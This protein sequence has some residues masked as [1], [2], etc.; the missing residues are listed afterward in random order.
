MSK[1]I[2]EDGNFA[3]NVIHYNGKTVIN[4]TDSQYLD[5]GYREY[6]EPVHEEETVTTVTNADIAKQREAAYREESD[7]LYMAYVKYKEQGLTEKA[8]ET[9]KEW[10]A[11]VDEID[12]RYPYITEEEE[13]TNE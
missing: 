5:A 4:P 6:I 11:K 2:D 10:L 7:Y 13:T 9:K 3:P 8:E 12:A 1:Y